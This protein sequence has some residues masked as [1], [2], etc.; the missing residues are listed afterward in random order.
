[1]RGDDDLMK[2]QQR[3]EALIRGDLKGGYLQKDNRLFF[4][5][6]IGLIHFYTFSQATK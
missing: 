3:T 6:T 1:M 5:A 2:I 4:L